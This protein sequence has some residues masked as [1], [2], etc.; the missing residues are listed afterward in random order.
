MTDSERGSEEEIGMLALLLG[1]GS[2][3]LIGGIVWRRQYYRAKREEHGYQWT[4]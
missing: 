3:T 1:L 2:L 4:K